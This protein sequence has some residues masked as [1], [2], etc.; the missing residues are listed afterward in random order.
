MRKVGGVLLAVAM[1]LPIG[2]VASP[3]GAAAVLTCTKLT[4][5]ATFT[6]PVS[7]TV[8]ATHKIVSHST[9]SGCT[10]TKGISSGKVTFT[11][12]SIKENCK[13]LLA[14]KKSST[15]TVTVKWNNGKVSGPGPATVSYVSLGV[16]KITSKM[17]N[18]PFKGK[19]S[20]SKTLFLPT[21]GGCLTKGKSLA[22]TSV[23]FAKGTKLTIS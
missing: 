1:V 8:S 13:I 14:N 16:V 17:T 11:S 15:A 5:T 12:T 18:G 9:I 10:G 6:P 4:G 23:S 19:T 22:T 20:V 21:G 2:L 7:P 3:A